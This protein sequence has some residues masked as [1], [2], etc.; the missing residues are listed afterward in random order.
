[1]ILKRLF[2]LVILCAGVCAQAQVSVQDQQGRTL[3]G[4]A[5]SDALVTVVLNAGGARDANLHILEVFSDHFTFE[6][7]NGENGSY[8]F[9]SVKEIRVQDGAIQKKRSSRNRAG[10]LTPSDRGVVKR[11]GA[12]AYEIFNESEGNQVLR[13]AAAGVIG[14]TEN[15]NAA[16]A[17]AYLT[18]RAEGNDLSTAVVANQILFMAGKTP[19]EETLRRGMDSGLR[20]IRGMAAFTAG[21]TGNAKY[22]RD[23]ARLLKDSTTYPSAAISSARVGD[24]SGVELMIR[25]IRSLDDTKGMASVF[26]LS[27][28]GGEKVVQ[29]MWNIVRTAHGEPWFRALSVL[30]ALGDEEAIEMM[31]AE[32]LK[33]REHFVKAAMLLTERGDWEAKTL[34]RKY[35]EEPFDGYLEDLMLRMKVLRVLIQTDDVPAKNRLASIMS[36]TDRGVMAHGNQG[37]KF[38]KEVTLL[39]VKALGCQTIGVIG[40]RNLMSTLAP[41]VENLNPVIALAAC[42]AAIAIADPDYHARFLASAIGPGKS[43]AQ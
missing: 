20:Q 22:A 27:T 8:R 4:L 10:I 1:M 17:V 16:E 30:T 5:G 31:S 19:D 32:A 6:Q 33:K 2:F 13:M 12:R 9:A 39:L 7:Q 26:A 25:G 42:D 14:A 23:I 40:N 11:A 18:Q 15:E 29:A 24:R 21:L 41:L 43:T 35:I 36:Y 28:L 38:Q 37:V 3:R 34:L